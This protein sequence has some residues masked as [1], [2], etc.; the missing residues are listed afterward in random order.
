MPRPVP[1]LIVLLAD[2]ARDHGGSADAQ[3]HRECVDQS[4][5]G[6]RQANSSHSVRAQTG[7]EKTSTA[8]TLSMI[9]SGTMGIASI[10]IAVPIG[11]LGVV[12]FRTVNGFITAAKDWFWAREW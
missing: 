2:P 5:Q 3:S 9:I 4:Q 1:P 11:P 12:S 8:N 7:H 6:L 10:M